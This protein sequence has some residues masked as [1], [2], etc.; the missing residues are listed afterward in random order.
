MDSFNCR[1]RDELLNETRSRRS[2][3]ARKKIRAWKHDYNHD[4]PH[5]GIGNIPPAEFMAKK[6]LELRAA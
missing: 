6:G 4:R 1:L 5:S 3:R 2:A